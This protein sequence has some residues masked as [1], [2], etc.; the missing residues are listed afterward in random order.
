VSR[1]WPAWCSVWVSL[2][3]G[4]RVHWVEEVGSAERDGYVAQAERLLAGENAP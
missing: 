3:F 4:A 1:C 2:V